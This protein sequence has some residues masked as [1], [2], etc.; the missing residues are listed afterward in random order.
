[1]IQR[2]VQTVQGTV[3]TIRSELRVPPRAR[4]EQWT[5]L[6]G[7]PDADPGIEPAVDSALA[8]LC[9]AQDC[10]RSHDGGVARHFSLLEGWG[11]SYPETTGYI[12][13]TV[14]DCASDRA[15]ARVRARARA[16]L[17]WLVS[18]QF[19]DGGFQ[20]GTIGAAPVV[21][22][23]FNTGQILLGLAR[24]V[25][26]WGDQYRPPMRRAAD[27]LVA[28]QD[29]DGCWRKFQSPFAMPGEHTYHTHVAWGLLEAA[30]LEPG[31]PYADAALANVRW[32]L[33]HQRSNGWLEKCCLD[34]PAAPLTHTVGYA[35]RGILEAYRFSDDKEL[36]RRSRRMADGLLGALRRDGFLPGRLD[37]GWRGTVGWS[38][39]TGNVQIAYCWLLL[40][41]L[42]ADARYREA[43]YAV[44]GYVRRTVRVRGPADTRG[45]VKGSHPVS[46][47]YGR[48][49]YLSWAAKFF[50][51]SNLFER[52]VRAHS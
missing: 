43:A 22:T 13:P 6:R 40:Y 34:G 32:A 1:M 14:L 38:C 35:L 9:H 5:D 26:E 18:I 46:G 39:L 50:I 8:W 42:T 27:W 21:P 7:V 28:A 19:A 36:L 52:S 24:G 16:M 25:R 47:G 2:L 48:F 37:A 12:I 4:A 29:P 45:G 20:A 30:R 33:G 49:E 17:D 44:N 41:Q 23:I 31:A 11:T 10:S 15:D 51:D 3:Q